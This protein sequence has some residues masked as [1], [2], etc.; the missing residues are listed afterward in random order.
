MK[1]WT[2]SAPDIFYTYYFIT[3]IRYSAAVTKSS[4]EKIDVT[5]VK[6]D[7]DYYAC[8]IPPKVQHPGAL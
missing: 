3:V 8:R 5:D 6:T 7:T 2:A 4:H 1:S